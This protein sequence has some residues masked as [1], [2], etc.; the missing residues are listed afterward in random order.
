MGLREDVGEM[1]AERES[2]A[3]RD[4][5]PVPVK[6][7]ESAA[8]AVASEAVAPELLEAHAVAVALAP[9]VAELQPL[10]VFEPLSV[11]AELA[12]APAPPLALPK[13]VALAIA[14]NEGG[15][16]DA[17]APSLAVAGVREAQPLAHGVAV[18]LALN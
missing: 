3:L 12:V 4:P 16:G 17:E 6:A 5:L 13:D 15:C 9:G 14:E 8:V 18:P 1:E 2:S 7:R 10:A 11:P